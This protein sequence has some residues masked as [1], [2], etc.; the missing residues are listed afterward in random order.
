M[1]NTRNGND[2][3]YAI[4]KLS[5]LKPIKKAI[6]VLDIEFSTDKSSF[7]IFVKKSMILKIVKN[8]IPDK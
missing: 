5:N 2:K 1:L 6:K 3:I 8:K 4:I 7:E